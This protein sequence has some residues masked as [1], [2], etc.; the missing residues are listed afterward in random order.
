MQTGRHKFFSFFLCLFTVLTQTYVTCADLGQPVLLWDRGGCTHWCMTGWYA[1]PALADLDG[2]GTL[3]AVWASYRVWV[4]DAASGTEYWSVYTGHDIHYSGDEYVGRTW[5]SPVVADVD[6]DG[7]LEIVTA[8]SGGWVCVY[9]ITGEFDPGWPVQVSPDSELRTL[10]A[11]DFEKDGDLEIV[12][13]STS[14]GND[15]EWY[16]LEHTGQIRSGWPQHDGSCYAA[17]CFNQNVAIADLDRDNRAEVI[18]P[19]DTHYICA[20]SDA[21]G[22]IPAHPMYDGRFWGQVGVWVDLEAELRGWG[23]C[24]TEHR[25]N[26]CHAPPVAADMN[27]DGTLEIVIVGNVHNC[28]TS[29]YTDLYEVPI[30]FNADR[31]RFAS[32]P[33]D[34]TVWPA[35]PYPGAWEA[36]SQ[37]YNRIESC[38]PNPTVADVDNDGVMELFYPSYDG[39]VHGFRLDKSEFGQWPYPVTDPGEGF[40]RFASEVL[41]ADLDGSGTVEIIFGSWTE[42]SSGRAGRL[43]ILSGYGEPLQIVDVPGEPGEWNGI[44]GAPTLG[45]IDGNGDLEL[46]AGTSSTGLI[47]YDLPGATGS[48]IRWGTGRGSNLRNGALETALPDMMIDIAPD[49]PAYT[50]GD[51]IRVRLGMANPRSNVNCDL[52]L[53][54]DVYGVPL[55]ISP[56][57]F[58]P[59]FTMQPYRF[60]LRPLPGGFT[61]DPT[62]IL[63]LY[64]GN[65]PLPTFSFDWYALLTGADNMNILAMDWENT[66][67]Y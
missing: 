64:L 48:D 19:N 14:F 8:H 35:P 7:A 62:E 1:S 2:N 32:G 59:N 4:F 43:H 53:A 45:D 47:A 50:A 27:G 37:D 49:S 63:A 18:G 42:K 10:A 44:L 54:I 38:H 39:K 25:P 11:Y 40:I 13:A 5:P 30:V 58:W 21:G 34:W 15:E 61:M 17:G 31:S 12:V 23:H 55:F 46:I 56:E 33:F 16:V 29:P 9:S 67:I 24:G 3:E 36:L 51:T 41:A 57:P 60:T 26:F 52:Y 20:F 65:A 66:Q 28:G 6:A 22:C